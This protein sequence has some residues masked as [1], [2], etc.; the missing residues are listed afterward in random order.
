MRFVESVDHLVDGAATAAANP[1]G[2]IQLREVD[3][4]AG[5]GESRQP[6]GVCRR[7]GGGAVGR[8]WGQRERHGWVFL[9]YFN[10]I[11]W[12]MCRHMIGCCK[13]SVLQTDRI[14]GA[15]YF[16]SLNPM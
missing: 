2:S 3:G 8:R 4:V 11:R 14:V 16:N 13:T 10:K 5:V 7:A 1:V 6:G 9:F 12:V 15:P